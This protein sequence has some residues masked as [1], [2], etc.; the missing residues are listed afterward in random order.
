MKNW[1]YIY[2]YTRAAHTHI[3]GGRYFLIGSASKTRSRNGN[4]ELSRISWTPYK[5]MASE[6]EIR[7][8]LEISRPSEQVCQHTR[9]AGTPTC[10]SSADLGHTRIALPSQGGNLFSLPPRDIYF[11]IV[12]T[13]SGPVSRLPENHTFV[14]LESGYRYLFI[15]LLHVGSRSYDCQVSFTPS[16]VQSTWEIWN[17]AR[18][19]KR[20]RFRWQETELANA[21][22]GEQYS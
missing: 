18:L 12:V 11:R 7:G 19:R 1:I 15:L 10:A 8:L 9:S 16:K 13:L 5:H 21:N 3:L 17:V 14:W 22:L 2:T 6:P 4:Y 20:A